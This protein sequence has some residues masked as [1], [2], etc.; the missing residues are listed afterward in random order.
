MSLAQPLQNLVI[1][2]LKG[3]KCCVGSKLN[4]LAAVKVTSKERR[5]SGIHELNLHNSHI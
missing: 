2:F 4:Y 3:L 5:T 1:L